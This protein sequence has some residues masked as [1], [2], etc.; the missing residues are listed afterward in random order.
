MVQVERHHHDRVS[1]KPP[2]EGELMLIEESGP[3]YF[4]ALRDGDLDAIQASKTVHDNG[5]GFRPRNTDHVSVCDHFVLMLSEQDTKKVVE[6]IKD[7]EG[8]LAEP[9]GGRADLASHRMLTAR[10]RDTLGPEKK[11]AS[12]ELSDF[13]NRLRPHLGADA[14]ERGKA[15][16]T[17]LK[18]AD[19]VGKVGK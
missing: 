6:T 19:A 10:L 17:L 15:L 4:R 12:S 16:D 18:M 7:V 1:A 3:S 2:S 8:K 5:R 13:Y 14:K 11:A 9:D